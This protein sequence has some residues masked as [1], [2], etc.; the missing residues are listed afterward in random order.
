MSSTVPFARTASTPVIQSKVGFRINL[1]ETEKK[2][3]Y[4]VTKVIPPYN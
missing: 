2:W 4:D 1:V 3:I